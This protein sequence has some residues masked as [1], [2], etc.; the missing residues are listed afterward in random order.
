ML[1][2]TEDAILLNFAAQWQPYGGPEAS[3]IFLR[4]G[5]G[6]GEFRARVH[7]ALTRAGAADMDIKVYRSLL[8]Y[9]SG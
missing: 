2:T 1:S 4:F 6:R 9:A 5:I 7:R 3:E 8:R